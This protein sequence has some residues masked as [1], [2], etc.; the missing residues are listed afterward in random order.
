[1]TSQRKR[2]T[3]PVLE[4]RTTNQNEQ[5]IL[6]ELASLTMHTFDHSRPAK[7]WIVGSPDAKGVWRGFGAGQ[8]SAM[9]FSPYPCDDTDILVLSYEEYKASL[10]HEDNA[11][12][13]IVLIC[14]QA[15]DHYTVT[16]QNLY[17]S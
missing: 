13:K 1:M 15:E 10:P 6:G 8:Q 4:T 11:S 12:P 9:G 17:Q 14:H 7:V 16:P 3:G 5:Q 2:D